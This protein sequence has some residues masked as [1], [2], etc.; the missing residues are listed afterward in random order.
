LR[1][2]RDTIDEHLKEF[3]AKNQKLEYMFIEKNGWPVATNQEL[4]LSVL[5]IIV[6]HNICIQSGSLSISSI[7]NT[8]NSNVNAI[9]EAQQLFA[10][11]SIKYGSNDE[12]INS[13]VQKTQDITDS[14]VP[15]KDWNKKSTKRGAFSVRYLRIDLNY[16]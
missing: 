9:Q 12:A 4:L 11:P 16:E 14:I 5:D 2:L 6:N 7:S 1:Q 3:G 15:G 13:N 10:L 8:S